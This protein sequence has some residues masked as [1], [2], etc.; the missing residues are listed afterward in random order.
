MDLQQLAI[1]HLFYN[2]L[3]MEIYTASVKKEFQDESDIKN[4]IKKWIL[5]HKKNK[6]FGNKCRHEIIFISK[7]IDKANIKEF[8]CKVANLERNCRIIKINME[9]KTIR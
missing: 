5:K 9:S 2:Q 6:K 3:L 7:E 4:E 8:R 1:I